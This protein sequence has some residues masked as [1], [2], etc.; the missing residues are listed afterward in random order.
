VDVVSPAV[1]PQLFRDTFNRTLELHLNRTRQRQAA[2]QGMHDW[3]AQVRTA[4][5]RVANRDVRGFGREIAHGGRFATPADFPLH[6]GTPYRG[7]HV[8]RERL[9]FVPRSMTILCRA[10]PNPNVTIRHLCVAVGAAEGEPR[11]AAGR[12][13]VRAPAAGR[14]F[15][16]QQLHG[17]AGRAAQGEEAG[18]RHEHHAVRL[19][20]RG[21]GIGC[22]DYVPIGSDSSQ[23]ALCLPGLIGSSCA[24]GLGRQ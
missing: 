23:S 17:A 10:V 16:H 20:G 22:L 6:D 9:G 14:L 7:L 1:G 18:G 15:S 19:R 21:A 8:R 12:R 5:K 13:S 3:L 2:D 11:H 4:M 24:T